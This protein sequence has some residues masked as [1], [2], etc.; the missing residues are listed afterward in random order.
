M[1]SFEEESRNYPTQL[2]T[3]KNILEKYNTIIMTTKTWKYFEALVTRTK[4]KAASDK[5]IILEE[6]E[7]NEM[8]EIVRNHLR[9]MKQGRNNEKNVILCLDANMI[10]YLSRRL[11]RA[12]L[13]R[14][15]DYCKY[16]VFYNCSQYEK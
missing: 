9:T 7:E 15:A 8:N 3:D 16:I 11:I 1:V 14:M 12:S 10:T 6:K 4:I 2:I 5:F 13:K